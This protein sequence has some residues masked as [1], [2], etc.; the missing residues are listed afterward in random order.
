MAAGG[1]GAH[2]RYRT[3]DTYHPGY[4]TGGYGGALIGGNASGGYA[5]QDGSGGSQTA[6]GAGNGSGAQA[7]TFGTGGYKDSSTGATSGSV[8]SGG[9]GYWGGGS[10]GYG[11]YNGGGGGGSSFISG[12]PG[13][14]AIAADGDTTAKTG[15]GEEKAAHYSG[16]VFVQAVTIGDT[17]Y[18]TAML[19][20]NAEM[21]APDGGTETG[22][23]GGGYARVV[24]LGK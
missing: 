10:G 1:G 15:A 19:T 8:G 5:G 22:H 12:Y 13:C 20:G 23:S 6:G 17:E 9:Y 16:K 24:Y 7:G 3:S 2:D 21:P 18:T 4:S 11:Y 14:V